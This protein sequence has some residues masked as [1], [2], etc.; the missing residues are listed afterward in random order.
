MTTRLTVRRDIEKP[1]GG[2]RYTVPETGV[3][4]TGDF[5]EELYG[6]VTSH[7]R[8]NGIPTDGDFRER[9]E[10]GACRETQP[11]GSRCGNAKPKPQA[12]PIEHLMLSH[13]ERFL[14][15]VWQAIMDRKFVPREEAQ[16]RL[17][18]CLTCPIRT[19]QP[20]GCNGCFTL[21]KKAHQLMGKNDALVIEPDEDGFV[22]DTC[23]ACGCIL[24][25][26]VWL[27]NQTLNTAEGSNRP[28]YW[29]G[30]WRNR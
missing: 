4:L 18:V 1:P 28:A 15:T 26:K 22:R 13:V 9:I 6:K 12:L 23:G 7:C 21:V 16:R 30:C 10:D 20:G 5:F 29:E 25:L 2:W 11:P 27:D 24:P 19:T 17:D 8:A 3:L 14:K